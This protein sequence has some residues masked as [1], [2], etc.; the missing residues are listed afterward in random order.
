MGCAAH[1]IWCSTDGWLTPMDTCARYTL[2]LP[3]E[4]ILANM[5]AGSGWPNNNA[6]GM[7]GSAN[8][9]NTS[10]A[11]TIRLLVCQACNKLSASQ[12]SSHRTGFH[13]V[14]AVLRQVELMKPASEGTIT[15]QEMLDICDTEGN[16]QNGG[17]S[18]IIESQ[19]DTGTFVKFESGRNTS[20]STRGGVPGDIGS[21]ISGGAF[22]GFGGLRP[23]QQPGGLHNPSGF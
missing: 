23:F 4:Y 18:F 21:P 6:F 14:D 15:L 7:I 20:M 19:G 10:R 13:P 17:G 8:R 9:P 5:C 2:L 12:T 3:T 1:A 16:N 11:V 22:P